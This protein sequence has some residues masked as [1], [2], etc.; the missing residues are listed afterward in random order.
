MGD[1]GD[2]SKSGGG[3]YHF[4]GGL[5]SHSASLESLSLKLSQYVFD[6]RAVSRL[7]DCVCG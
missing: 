7:V 5:F 6:V 3:V 4:A 2:V 1:R